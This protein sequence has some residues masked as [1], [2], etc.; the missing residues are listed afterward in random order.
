MKFKLKGFETMKKTLSLLLAL[1]MIL[2]LSATALAA[3][4]TVPTDG[5][6]KDHTFTAYQIF[7]GR[8]ENG[9]LSDVQWGSGINSDGFLAA[10]KADTTYGSKFTGCTDAADVAKVLSDNNSNAALANQVAKLAY[11]KKTGSGKTLTSG[12]NTLADGYYLVVDTTAD[13]G[14]GGAYNTAL[15]QV[16]GNINI[17]AK[18]DA[19]TSDKMIVEGNNRVEVNEASIGDTVQYEITGTLPSNLADY[20]TYYYVFTDTLSKGLTPVTDQDGKITVTVKIGDVDVT[21][22]FYIGATNYSETNGTTITVGIQD[23]LALNKVEGVTVN[24]DSKIVISYSAILNENAVIAGEGNPNDVTLKYSNKPNESGTGATEAPP[25]NPDQPKP[26]HPTGDTPKEKV[27]TFTTELTIKKT[28]E[29]GKILPGAEFKLEGNGV[30]VVLVTTEKFTEDTSGEY[31]KLTDGTYT[32]T[33]PTI[34]GDNDNSADYDNTT[35]KYTKTVEIVAKGKGKTE[36]TVVGMVDSENG[37]VTF[38]G[39]GAG[40]YKITE[41]KTPS[42]YNTI[43]PIDFTIEFNAET[44]T[45]SVKDVTAGQEIVVNGNTLS[46]TIVNKAGATLPETGGMGTT[47]FYALGSILVLGAGVLLV[48]KKRMSAE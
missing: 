41:T 8:E 5:I 22:Y 42:G 6:L 11:A 33:G 14:E 46:T 16:V 20:N 39:L 34:G 25:E 17:T 3:T 24:K 37:T 7:S 1:T 21:K 36:T 35:T 43:A 10:L 31:W 29:N 40:T 32:K 12:E 4:V 23:L 48:V 27:V 19:P 9:I 15:L 2:A 13:V 44:K 45:F 38:T 28:D 47:I 26:E 18:T 30:N